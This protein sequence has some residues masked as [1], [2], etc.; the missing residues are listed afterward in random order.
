MTSSLVGDHCEMLGREGAALAHAVF[1]RIDRRRADREA[2]VQ[3]DRA[4]F[5]EGALGWEGWDEAAFHNA[6]RDALL[7]ELRRVDPGNL[8]LRDEARQAVGEKGVKAYVHNGRR[9]LADAK[10]VSNG[11]LRIR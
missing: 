5:Q 7:S 6:V 10:V 1:D 4:R 11:A 9:A 3:A 2:V 8:L